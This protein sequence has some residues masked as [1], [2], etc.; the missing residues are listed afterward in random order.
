MPEYELAE[1]HARGRY[2]GSTC[3]V[4]TL[5]DN[6]SV[7]PTE[8]QYR[9]SLM[10]GHRFPRES[11]WKSSFGRFSYSAKRHKPL[12]SHLWFETT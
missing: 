6:S 1:I 2:T 10:L 8:L 3:S 11:Y 12:W 5:T 4:T 9:S 7:A